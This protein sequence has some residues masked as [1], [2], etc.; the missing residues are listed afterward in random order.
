G[1]V[2]ELGAL[3]EPGEALDLVDPPGGLLEAVGPELAA[4]EDDALDLEPGTRVQD[5][6]EEGVPPRL[7]HLGDL[8]GGV[9]VRLVE[10]AHDLCVGVSRELRLDVV[11][12]GG[13][14]GEAP[15]GEALAGDVAG[16]DFRAGARDWVRHGGSYF[17]WS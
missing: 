4:G 14:D 5:A 2:A 8:L 1:A 15:V 12:I 3:V 9:A 16:D 10:V 13:G 17:S 11:A 7:Q 6:P